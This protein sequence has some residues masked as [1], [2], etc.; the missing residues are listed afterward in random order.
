[1]GFINFEISNVYAMVHATLRVCTN[2]KTHVPIHVCIYI[3]YVHADDIFVM[4]KQKER[5]KERRNP[6]FFLFIEK[7]K[8]V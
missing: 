3:V 5:K 7:R 2:N 1:M 8:K 6:Q 4:N